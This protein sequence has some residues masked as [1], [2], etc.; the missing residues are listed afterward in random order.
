MRVFAAFALLALGA[1][2]VPET[3]IPA[4]F[5][6]VEGVAWDARSRQM[7]AG[8]VEDG[9][10]L[11]REGDHWRRAVLPYGTAGLFGMAVDQRRGILWISSGVAGPTVKANGF[12]GLIGVT[13]QGF[14]P[15]GRASVPAADTLAQPGDVVIAPD[16]SVYVSDGATGNVYICKPGCTTLLQL[17]APGTFRS[18]QGMAVS[19]DG[20]TLYVAD[21]GRGLFRVDLKKPKTAILVAPLKG[22]D[23][24]VR[25][26][27]AL[28]AIINGDGSRI[29]RLSFD[30]QGAVATEVL[31]TPKGPGDAT[32]GV[33]I[34]GQLVYIADA[35]WDRFDRSGKSIAKARETTIR[36]IALPS[37]G[38]PKEMPAIRKDS[39][40]FQ[41]RR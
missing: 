2:D 37:G 21:Y 29:V 40:G 24:L 10:L 22:I 1:A 19:R 28:L 25:D 11:V 35:Q 27:D 26:G 31:A 15:V 6:L 4:E 9:A 13:A 41:D 20:R 18:A 14:V 16:G 39:P 7:F 12:R 34:A 8:T 33:I 5:G 17:V 3:I 30:P 32:L 36:A 23:G 38:R